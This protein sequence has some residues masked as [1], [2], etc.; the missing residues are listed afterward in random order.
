MTQTYR[1]FLSEEREGVLSF[2]GARMALLDIEAGFWG[3]RSQ[4]EA[5]VG[6]ELTDAVLQQAGA[7]G[8]ASFARS[9]V[10]QAAAPQGSQAFR[11]CLAAYQAAGFGRFEIDT[12]EW[13]IG[14]VLI[15]GRDAFEAWAAQH[16]GKAHREPVC[17]YTAGVLVGFIN[18]V[19][20]RN[21]VVCVQRSCQVQGADQCIFE[22][23]PAD[24]AGDAPV[25]SF[26][27]DPAL[28][29][30][31]N[32]L[33]ILFERMPMGIV[34]VDRD[35]RVRRFNPTWAE[36]L[37]RYTS[38]ASSPIVPG[39]HYF[40]LNPGAEGD[41]MPIFERVL[42]GETVYLESFPIHSGKVVSYWNA[43]LSPL[44]EDDEVV[45]F[46]N[47]TTDATERRAAE[48]AL[49]ESQRALSTLI[50]N[51]PGMAY[52]CRNDPHW[53]MTFV[54]EGSLDLTGYRPDELIESRRISYGD[55]IH[56][57]DRE[58]VWKAVQVG[59][60]DRKPFQMTYRIVTPDG[61]KWVWEQGRGVYSD[62][63][64]LLALEGFMT[65]ITERVMNEQTLEQ[66]VDE[67]TQE[68]E[69]RRRVAE[70]LREILRVLN[71]TRSLDDVL[72][73]I[74]GQ[75]TQLLGAQAG[76]L[77]R[78]EQ[79]GRWA[80]FEASCGL[81]SE[82]TSVQSMTV[83]NSSGNQEILRGQP[84]GITDF[85]AY[86]EAAQEDPQAGLTED[87][88]WWY[89]RLASLYESAMAVPLILRDRVYGGLLF[90]YESR[91]RFSSD[92]YELGISLADQAA[93]AIENA[94]LR[95]QAGQAAA[96]EER[97][98]LARELH[99]SV[100]QALYGIGLGARTAR[101]LLDRASLDPE[102]ET[103]L[104]DPLDYVLALADA[105]LAEMRALIFEL[106][107]DALEKEGLAAALRRQ[108]ETVRVRHSLEVE[109]D[110]CDEPEIPLDA[111][112]ALYRIAQEALNNAVQHARA[113]RI[114]IKLAWN[115][116]V[117]HL[118][119]RDDGVGF[120]PERRHP[121]HLGLRSMQE[122]AAQV[123]GVLTIQSAPQQGT[124]VQVRIPVPVA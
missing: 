4:M 59:V 38:P 11:D 87:D 30:Q 1:D 55:L 63:G 101:T 50:S 108:A 23:L 22:L 117:V 97:Q 70:G 56:P 122:R 74:I 19:A 110:L 53:T 32:L 96:M 2:S 6:R 65:D 57:E 27:P 41:L 105:G 93:L 68:I 72:D 14:R 98:R 94:R 81:P 26:A 86:V 120:D 85:A 124:L 20:D 43:V 84:V 13:P 71:S 119:V 18:V 17:A 37:T 91:H 82:L 115:E 90:Y 121:G 118:S 69:Q 16:H 109:V 116:G 5:L 112:E 75:A 106:R 10:N 64:A 92:D 21:D 62:D 52:R 9:F 33:E 58:M 49:E 24:T 40:D 78:F 95:V 104:A 102:I 47:V 61:V 79:D 25:V 7:N 31:L 73:Y 51:L 35:L 12:L 28:S 88:E 34:V 36:F 80:V 103:R 42:A 76:L 107:P 99:D 100:S 89:G 113:G 77:F 8:G 83:D 15:R 66:R 29:R 111:R 45:G 3:L 67:R 39:A 44:V 54:S 123:G 60:A 114:E 48:K 46:L